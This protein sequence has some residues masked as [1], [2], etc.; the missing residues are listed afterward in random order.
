MIKVVFFASLKEKLDCSGLNI[1]AS[2]VADLDQ[3]KQNLMAKSD[4]WQEALSN[5]VLIAVNQE[6]VS[7]NIDL[8]DG[9]EVAFFPP[10]TGG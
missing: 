8:Q 4:I 3:L 1:D 9:A 5:K 10:V 7:S 2:E 6:L